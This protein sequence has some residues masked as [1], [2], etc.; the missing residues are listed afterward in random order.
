MPKKKNKEYVH[1][2]DNGTEATELE[3][4]VCYLFD[5]GMTRLFFVKSL[6]VADD[7]QNLSVMLVFQDINDQGKV[8][9]FVQSQTTNQPD[10]A[11]ANNQLIK[12]NAG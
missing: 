9:K 3:P 8:M 10:D 4:G 11:I 7:E 1:Q 2:L 6:L 5:N 12:N